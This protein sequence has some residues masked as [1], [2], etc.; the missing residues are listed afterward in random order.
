MEELSEKSV[1]GKRQ[2]LLDLLTD[3]ARLHYWYLG[4]KDR[5][6]VRAERKESEPKPKPKIKVIS[7]DEVPRGFIY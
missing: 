3:H 7:A 1:Y 4:W 6:A 2:I 5:M